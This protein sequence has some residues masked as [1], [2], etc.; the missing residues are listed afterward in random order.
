VLQIFNITNPE[1]PELVREIAGLRS[2]MGLGIDGNRLFLCDKTLKIFDISNP[3]L[4][5]QT[6]DLYDLPDVDAVNAYD[7][8]L[9]EGLLILVAENGIF[10]FR[11]TDDSFEFLS[12]IN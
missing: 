5:R 8:I 7:V 11:Y 10:Q 9:F 12:K 2:P 4:P 1:A 3:E 6:G